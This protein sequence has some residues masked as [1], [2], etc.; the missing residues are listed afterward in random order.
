MS[1]RV[2]EIEN[3]TYMILD[4]IKQYFWENWLLISNLNGSLI[5]DGGGI[6]RYLSDKSK[7]LYEKKEELDSQ[8]EKY[9]NTIIIYLGE[10]GNTV[11]GL[12]V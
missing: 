5:P 8:P 11:G 12:I 2:K 7:G 3:P 1:Y 4:E 9:G 10:K 6:V